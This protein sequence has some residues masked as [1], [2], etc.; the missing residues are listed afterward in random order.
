MPFMRRPEPGG[1]INIGAELRVLVQDK[2]GVDFSMV[3]FPDV[4]NDL[5]PVG[6]YLAKR[7]IDYALRVSYLT[8]N[9]VELTLAGKF[10]LRANN[11]LVGSLYQ[12]DSI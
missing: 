11:L 1:A 8:P 10:D 9:K 5:L 3:F 6:F 2:D 12:V 7:I 4:N